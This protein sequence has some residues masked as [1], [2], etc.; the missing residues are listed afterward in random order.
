[1]VCLIESW[2]C[3]VH[4]SP[5]RLAMIALSGVLHSRCD[6]WHNPGVAGVKGSGLFDPWSNDSQILQFFLVNQ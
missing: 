1:M 6:A 4:G 5:A 3:A 2:M